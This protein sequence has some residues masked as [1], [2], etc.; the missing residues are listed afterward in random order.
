MSVINTNSLS[1][2]AQGNLSKSQGALGQAIERLSSGLRINSAKDDAAGQ[3]IANRFTANIKGLSQA[4]RNANDG[5]SIAQTTEGAL[6]EINNNLQRVRELS[7]QAANSSNSAEDRQSIQ[8]EINERLAEINRVSR[9]TDFNGVKVLGD[10]ASALTIQVGAKDGQTIKIDLKTINQTTLKLDG[11]NIGATSGA[12]KNLSFTDSNDQTHSAEITL[13]L[14][15][16]PAGLDTDKFTLHGYG[17]LNTSTGLYANYAL[18][19]ENGVMYKVDATAMEGDETDA[20]FG[21]FTFDFVD[22]STA[23]AAADAYNVDVKA[24]LA[25]TI[26]PL[27]AI[28]NALQSVDDL[29]SHLGAIQNRFQST[30]ANLNNTVT[31]LSAARSRIEDADYA[32]EVSNMTRAQIL[33][34]AGTSVLAQANQVPQSVLSLLR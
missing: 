9:E 14:S 10:D 21:T 34:Q 28:D 6:N 13:A 12:L 1:L 20:A 3:A 11:F 2:V 31:N 8:N 24:G 4:A 25:S 5:V 7:V 26:N 17:Q 16:A 33:Q 30:I 22:A 18:K 23:Q 15:N 32:V 19:D 29:R 27:E